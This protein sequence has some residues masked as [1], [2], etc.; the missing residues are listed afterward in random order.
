[1]QE[2]AFTR[3]SLF[4]L[5]MS[6]ACAAAWLLPNHHKP[7]LA[8]HSDAWL[9]SVMAGWILLLYF[10]VRPRVLSLTSFHVFLLIVALL[11]FLQ[12]SVGVLPLVGDAWIVSLYLLG[13]FSASVAGTYWAKSD[14]ESPVDFLFL[15][16]ILAGVISVGLQIYQWL[17][18]T[19]DDGMTDIMV[20][21]LEGHSRPYGNIG[22]PN[23]LATL[24]LMAVAATRWFWIR[25][26]FRSSLAILICM[27]LLW[28]VV[29]T[30][31]RTAMLSI[32][33]MYLYV[34]FRQVGFRSRPELFLFLWFVFLSTSLGH[35]NAALGVDGQPSV[36]TR[37]AGEI[38]LEAWKLFMDAAVSRPWFGYGWSGVS[39]AFVEH[40]ENYPRLH[41]ALFSHSHNIFLDIILWNGLLIGGLISLYLIYWGVKKF[42]GCNS[43]RD[44]VVLL[45]LLPVFVHSLLE[46]PLH[47]AYFLL[48]TC[49]LIGVL[50][51]GGRG[52]SIHRIG[53]SVLRAFHLLVCALLLVCVKDYLEVERAYFAMRFERAGIGTNHDRRLPDV[54]M[55]YQLRDVIELTRQEKKA[56]YS[57]GEVEAIKNLVSSMPSSYGAARFLFAATVS[58][59]HAMVEY[60]APKFC[61]IFS[62][63][64]C[65]FMMREIESARFASTVQSGR[66]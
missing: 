54:L 28:G 1:M 46:L 59:E 38:R 27:W 61:K 34:I 11:P 10:F 15:A 32:L 25:G 58:G 41:G 39:L 60:W 20:L 13:A 51:S 47:Y 7:W 16:I 45:A 56:S 48:P 53:I 42:I 33:M 22:Q 2:K 55:L 43:E 30:E 9:S 17:G 40:I 18:M 3:Q 66:H 52:A 63:P 44:C 50:E 35:I 62:A 21:H 14:A 24:L 49:F 5:M 4:F 31:S 65:Q 37:T 57:M 64:E 8:F 12:Y 36:L 26:L 29:L 19:H 23:Q 6:M